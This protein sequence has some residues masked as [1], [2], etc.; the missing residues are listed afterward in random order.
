MGS[1]TRSRPEPPAEGQL[2]EAFGVPVV[3]QF[4]SGRQTASGVDVAAIAR[5]ALDE[6][7]LARDLANALAGPGCA[8]PSFASEASRRSNATC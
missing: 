6:T 1:S 4:G 7:D 8:R 3:D 5:G 2:A